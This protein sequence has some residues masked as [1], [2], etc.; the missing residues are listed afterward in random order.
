MRWYG[1][2]SSPDVLYNNMLNLLVYCLYL[3]SIGSWLGQCVLEV[4]NKHPNL[5]GY[6]S[7]IDYFNWSYTS[8]VFIKCWENRVS[9]RKPIRIRVSVYTLA[10]QLCIFQVTVFD[11]SNYSIELVRLLTLHFQKKINA[12]YF[13]CETC[14]VLSDIF[15]DMWKHEKEKNKNITIITNKY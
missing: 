3:I 9:S 11:L 12:L 15:S 13:C 10:C 7:N 6:N 4:F 8:N 2:L 5:Q 1:I 14:L